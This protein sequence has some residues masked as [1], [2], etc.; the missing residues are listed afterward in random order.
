[1][2]AHLLFPSHPLRPSQVEPTFSDQLDAFAAAGF[3][4]SVI[5]DSV[6][7]KGRP[8]RNIPSGA[9]VVYRGWMLNAEDYQRLVDALT[10]AGATALTSTGQYLAAHHLPNWYPLITELTPET[11]VY[12]PAA[13]FEAELRGLGWDAFFIKDY[14]KSLKTSRGSI[15]HDPSEIG[16][17]IDEMRKYRGELEGGLCVRRVERFVPDSERRFFVLGG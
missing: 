6:L 5:S 3:T 8:L 2:K 9:T 4:T 11:R 16:E 7:N 14:V 1:M 10:A 13:N 15:V 17:V 12:P